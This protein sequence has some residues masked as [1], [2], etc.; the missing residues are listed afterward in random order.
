MDVISAY[1]AGKAVEIEYDPGCCEVR[2]RNIGNLSTMVR[3]LLKGERVKVHQNWTS[4][5]K[6]TIWL[7]KKDTPQ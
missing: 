4:Q 7:T 3:R 5:T 1:R 2:L 6:C